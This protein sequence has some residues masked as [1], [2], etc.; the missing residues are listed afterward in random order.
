[1]ANR[2]FQGLGKMLRTQNS[3][4]VNFVLES[5]LLFEQISP[6]KWE[7]KWP[8][9]SETGIKGCFEEIQ[10]FPFRTFCY[11]KQHSSIA[12]RNFCQNNQNSSGIE[13]NFS[14]RCQLATR[15]KFLVANL[16]FLVTNL[17]ASMVMSEENASAL[18]EVTTLGVRVT[19]SSKKIA[20]SKEKT[21]F[22][23][24]TCITTFCCTVNILIA[25]NCR[26]V[27]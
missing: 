23:G 26:K 27:K 19:R 8:A 3:G 9:R 4:L 7:I 20:G 1:M 14:I 21:V 22:T 11:E 15:R 10:E 13:I 18:M 16:N 6:I 5:R 25:F 2:S 12:S 24:L 17:V